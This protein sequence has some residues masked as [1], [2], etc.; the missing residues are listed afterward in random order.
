MLQPDPTYW[1]TET[2]ITSIRVHAPCSGLATPA[3][4]HGDGLQGLFNESLPVF[5]RDQDAA[6]PGGRLENCTYVHIDCDLYGGESSFPVAASAA[7]LRKCH[8]P[9]A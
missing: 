3:T 6:A 9:V 1:R 8:L 2:C 7:V 4:R 5:L